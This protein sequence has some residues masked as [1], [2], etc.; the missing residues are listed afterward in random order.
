V[1]K[2]FA[3]HFPWIDRLFGTWHM[4]GG[5]WPEALGID[6]HPVPESFFGQLVYPFRRRPRRRED[7]KVPQRTR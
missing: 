3:L 4:P 6:G 1:D 2:N 7:A 5:A